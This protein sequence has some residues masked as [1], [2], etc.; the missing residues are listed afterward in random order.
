M[1][2]D[3]RAKQVTWQ[4]LKAAAVLMAHPREAAVGL[5]RRNVLGRPAFF[6]GGRI[7]V[8][9]DLEQEPDPDSRVVLADTV[10]ALGLRQ[11]RVDWRVSEFEPWLLDGDYQSNMVGTHH[12]IGTTRMASDPKDGVV[13]TNCQVF[14]TT[15]L[16]VAG[17]S[18]FPTGGHANPTLTIVALAIRLAGHLQQELAYQKKAA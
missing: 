18:V 10:D 11:L 2:G 17:S 15:N 14:G 8:S 1:L 12:H 3:L 9:M 13:D 16:Y 4:T 7:S 5:W 6:Y